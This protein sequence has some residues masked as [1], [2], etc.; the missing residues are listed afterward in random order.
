MVGTKGGAQD[1]YYWASGSAAPTMIS[2]ANV[3]L[4]PSGVNNKGLYCGS[5]QD[6]ANGYPFVGN[7][8]SGP[9]NLA[10][11]LDSSGTGWTLYRAYAINNLGWV[12]GDGLDPQGRSA[13]FL[14]SPQ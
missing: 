2:I 1:M 3:T 7:L 5:A 4:I 11:L 8:A 14:A 9:V 12:V 6:N 13:G 10:T